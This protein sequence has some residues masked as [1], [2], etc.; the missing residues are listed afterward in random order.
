M[1]LT[2][3]AID[4]AVELG[5]IE[6]TPYDKRQLGPNSYDLRLS[7]VYST[8]LYEEID[9]ALRPVFIECKIPKEGLRLD[10]GTLYLMATKEVTHTSKYVPCIEGRSSVGRLGINVHATAGFGDIGF[11]GTWTLEVSCIQPVRIYAN[12]RICQ[13]Y[14]FEPKTDG[15]NYRL[16]GGKYVGQKEPKISGIYRERSEWYV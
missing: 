5:H 13:I 1:I 7:E 8:S 12:M 4:Q 10:P 6:I 3:G 15:V 9:A 2:G 11:K 14:F 16:Y